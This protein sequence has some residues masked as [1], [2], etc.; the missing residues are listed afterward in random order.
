[1][2]PRSSMS[3]SAFGGSSFLIYVSHP[4]RKSCIDVEEGSK[5]EMFRKTG[6]SGEWVRIDTTFP[7]HLHPVVYRTVSTILS[8]PNEIALNYSETS[9]RLEVKV[10]NVA[11]SVLHAV[12]QK[13][14]V[15]KPELNPTVEHVAK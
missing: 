14:F 10:K 8:S 13:K 7:Y 9:D 11:K 12:H 4:I 15:T 1:M 2:V 3:N 5:R 6:R